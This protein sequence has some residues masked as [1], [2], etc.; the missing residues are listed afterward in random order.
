[1]NPVRHLTQNNI[2]VKLSIIKIMKN[3]KTKIISNGVN[4]SNRV[5]NSLTFKLT[6]AV[7][8]LSVFGSA[9]TAFA[10]TPIFGYPKRQQLCAY[11]Q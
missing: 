10:A 8:A 1:M 2:F 9:G 6:A 5:K 3:L 11:G 4:A 7:F